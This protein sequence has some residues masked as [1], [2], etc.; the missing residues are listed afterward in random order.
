MKTYILK[1]ESKRRTHTQGTGGDPPSNI[2][3]FNFEEVLQLLTPEAGLLNIPEG[4]INETPCLLNNQDDINI[5]E[6]LLNISENE[7]IHVEESNRRNE[8][9]REQITEP[10]V[11]VTEINQRKKITKTAEKIKKNPKSFKGKL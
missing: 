2:V 5:E 1:K 6:S 9:E 3:F 10:D 4:G 7:I 11:E 8:C